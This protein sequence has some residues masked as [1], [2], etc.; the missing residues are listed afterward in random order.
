MGIAKHITPG[1]RYH[2]LTV[3][4]IADSVNGKSYSMCRCDCGST[5]AVKNV[6]LRRSNTR[7][8][9]CLR[10]EYLRSGPTTHGMSRSIEYAIWRAMRSRCEY[11]KCVGWKNYGGRGI[12]VCARW[13]VFDNFLADMGRRPSATHSIDRI[14]NNG[15]YCP[16]NCRWATRVQQAA[17]QRRP[18]MRLICAFGET[19]TISNWAKRLNVSRDT[20]TSRLW[21]TG[22]IE[23]YPGAKLKIFPLPL[24][25]DAV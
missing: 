17:T 10:E 25:V 22:S 12:K 11:P 4:S 7:S 20:L 21:R 16:E 5:I 8:C 15:D 6:H 3:I 1:T 19:D 18:T 9:G 2:R 24:G 13:R 23:D 14:D